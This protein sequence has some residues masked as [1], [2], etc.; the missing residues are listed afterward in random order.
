ML[1]DSREQLCLPLPY[2]SRCLSLAHE[3]FSHAGRNKMCLHIKRYFYWPSMTADVSHHCKSCNKCQKHTKQ[4]PKHMPMQEHEV[5]PVPSERV[6]VDIVG[7]FPTAKGGFRF[8]LTYIYMA[9]RWP[10]AIPLRKTTTIVM[11]EQLTQVFSRNGFPSTLM[12]DNGPSLRLIPSR[13]F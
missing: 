13:S 10:E 9:T 8:L 6:C 12:S 3:Q 11:I 5:V 4:S 1:G 2:R 7:S